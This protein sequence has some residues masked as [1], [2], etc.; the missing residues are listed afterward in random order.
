MNLFYKMSMIEIGQRFSEDLEKTSSDSLNHKTVFYELWNKCKDFGFF[1]IINIFD[2]GAS[3]YWDNIVSFMYGVGLGASSM[4]IFFSVNVQ[5]WA[6]IF[7]I[8]KYAST[9]IHNKLIH[10]LSQGHLICAHAISENMAGSDVFNINTE[11]VK[12]PEGYILNGQK[13]YVTNAPYADVYLVYARKKGTTGYDK[14]SCFLVNKKMQGLYVGDMISKMGMEYSPMA[15]IYLNNCQVDSEALL[16]KENQGVFIFNHAMMYE[17]PLLLAFQIGLMENQLKRNV[18]F[19][20]ERKQ[21]GVAIIKHQSVSNRLADMKV[22]LEACKLFLKDTILK[23][24]KDQGIY[25]SSS[26]AKL[27]IS[28]KLVANSMMAMENYGTY[29]YI[30][31]CVAEQ[32][33]RDSLGALFYSGTSDIQRNII[34]KF[35]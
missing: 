12:T 27:F 4:G 8:K 6:C 17:R 9:V 1:N 19:C 16:G 32:N 34:S 2:E 7:P 30:K 20:K 23:L 15:S 26:I 22:N 3:D 13:N 25:E 24:K 10:E 14:I 5:L 21:G 18:K 29:G 35:L 31:E 33:L 11:Y 28:E